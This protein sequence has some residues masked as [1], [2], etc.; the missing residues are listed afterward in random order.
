MVESLAF[1][2]GGCASSDQVT[3]TVRPAIRIPNAFTPNADNN[4]DTWQIA[5][6]DAY[7]NIHV[8]IFNRWGQK[9]FEASGYNRSNEWNGTISGQPAP[10]GTY[11]YLITLGNGKFYTG[12]LTIVY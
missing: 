3:V 6:I 10:I 7:P 9:L 5:N 11:Y 2:A 1:G 8:V 4:D 12:P